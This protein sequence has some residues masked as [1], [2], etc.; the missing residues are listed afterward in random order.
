M[1]ANKQLEE[2][3]QDHYHSHDMI[4][5]EGQYVLLSDA[6]RITTEIKSQLEIER[7]IVDHILH[8]ALTPKFLREYITENRKIT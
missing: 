8:N 4:T 6:V 7:K 1:D 3:A 2:K 5:E